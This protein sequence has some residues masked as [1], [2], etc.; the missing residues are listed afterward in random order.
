MML[1]I[2][3]AILPLQCPLYGLGANH[4]KKRDGGKRHLEKSLRRERIPGTK[5]IQIGVKRLMCG[6]NVKV[7]M[8]CLWEGYYKLG[9]ELFGGV[10]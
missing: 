6:Y 1:L 10:R 4:L 9:P 2:P 3:Q 5:G 8:C 7:S